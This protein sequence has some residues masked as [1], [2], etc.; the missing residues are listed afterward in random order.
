MILDLIAHPAF[1]QLSGHKKP[2]MHSHRLHN[3]LAGL[4]R[5]APFM[6]I[7]ICLAVVLMFALLA[8]Y[9][10]P[11][12]DD[13]CMASGVHEQG[14]IRHLWEH[15]F[16]W[17]GRYTSNALY[18]IYPVIFGLFQGYKFIPA[19]VMLALFL[20]TAFCLSAVF[21]VRIY[22]RA[23]W[24]YSLSFLSIFLLGMMSPASGLYWMAGAFTYQSANILFLVFLGLM[25]RLADRQKGLQKS[26]GLLAALLLV[27]ALAMGTNETSM[28]ALTGVAFLGVVVHLRSGLT[29]LKPWLMLL[30]VTLVCFA[31]VYFSPG[32][33]IRAADF[34]LRHDLSRSI[35]GSLSIGLKI[36]WQ[37]ISNPVLIISSLLAPFAVATLLQLSDRR[38]TVSKTMTAA[39]ILFTFLMPVLLQ[40]PAWWSMGGWPPARTVDAIYFLFLLGWYLSLGAVTVRYLNK[41]KWQAIVPPYKPAATLLLLLLVILFTAAVLESK[42][43]Q[44]AKTDLFHLAR[45]YHEY[46]HQRYQQIEQAKADGLR[47]LVVADYQQAYPRSLFFNDIM[48]NPDHWRNVCYADYFGLEEIKRKSAKKLRSK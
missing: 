20:A 5:I 24:L 44:L 9:S 32:N 43:Y 27:A 12:S 14:L 42:A 47:Q 38:F 21:R 34:P 37:W 8:Q 1:E 3:K 39:L 35:S 7:A 25:I 23:V 31:I 48:R 22:A 45:P 16:E 33:A 11:S 2:F 10:H 4:A 46:L 19:F 15:Y 41:G 18:A 13:F 28:L 26:T 30:A 36:L 17:S 29:I 40:F 6:L